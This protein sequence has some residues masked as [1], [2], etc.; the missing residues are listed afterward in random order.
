MSLYQEKQ[1]QLESIRKECLKGHTVRSRVQYLKESEKSTKNFCLLE[2]NNYQTK[3][4]ERIQ[5]NNGT[6]IHDLETILQTV[7][8][9]Y[10]KLFD[11]KTVDDIELTDLVNNKDNKKL[12][13]IQSQNLEGTNYLWKSTDLESKSDFRM[14]LKLVTRLLWSLHS[15]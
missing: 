3:T 11:Q 10:A 12:S 9:Y 6:I 5:L 8:N 4:I 14:I 1:A 7:A 2:K 13:D 15:S